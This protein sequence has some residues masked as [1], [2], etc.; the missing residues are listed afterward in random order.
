MTQIS[1]TRKMFATNQIEV[2]PMQLT[3]ARPSFIGY[4]KAIVLRLTGFGF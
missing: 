3:V 2:R 4:L 1:A